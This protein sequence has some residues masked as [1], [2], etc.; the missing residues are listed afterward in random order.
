MAGSSRRLARRVGAAAVSVL[1]VGGLALFGQAPAASAD[2]ASTL[3]VQG[4]SFKN[5]FNPWTSYVQ[6]DKEIITNIYPSLT[7]LNDKQKPAPY[8]ADSWTTSSDGLTWTFKIHP[9]LKWS[10]GQ[11]LTAKDAAWTL[12]LIMTN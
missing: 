5:N 6:G 8:L 9:D 10:D 12:N 11:P 4:A 2:S 1:L 3:I 7:Y